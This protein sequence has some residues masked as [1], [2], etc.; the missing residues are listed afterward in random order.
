MIWKKGCNLH[1]AAWNWQSKSEIMQKPLSQNVPCLLNSCLMQSTVWGNLHYTLACG[2]H[3]H[4]QLLD[5]PGRKNN[6]ITCFQRQ[7]YS[8]DSNHSWCRMGHPC[9][10]AVLL[11][12]QRSPSAVALFLWYSHFFPVIA[13]QGIWCPGFL[14][15]SSLI[16]QETFANCRSGNVALAMLHQPAVFSMEELSSICCLLNK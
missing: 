13:L 8:W 11:P 14:K 5:L 12:I 6:K 3:T 4:T 2:N 15:F 16:N 9:W 1:D 10:S 7:S